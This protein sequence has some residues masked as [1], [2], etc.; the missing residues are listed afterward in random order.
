MQL[1]FEFQDRGAPATEPGPD[2]LECWRPIDGWP[3]Y[4]VSDWGRVHTYWRPGG[5]KG[6][7]GRHSIGLTPKIMIGGV[8]AKGH[9]RVRLLKDA[10][11]EQRMVY[12]HTLV[13]EAFVGPRPPSMEA[14]HNDGNPANN[15][16]SNLRWD[17]SSNNARDRLKHGVWPASS[18]TESMIPSIWRRLV[19]GESVSS[20]A[21]ELEVKPHVISLIKN[22]Q[23][24]N[25]ITRYLPG[26]SSRPSALLTDFSPIH[27]PDELAYTKEELWRTMLDWPG[28]QFSNRGR[29]KT[30][31]RRTSRKGIPCDD[32]GMIFV[33]HINRNG[34]Y[35]LGLIDAHGRLRTLQIH[36]LLLSAFAGPKP[37]RLLH[38]CH[39]DGN[40][41]NNWAYNLRWDTP[42][43]NAADR[44][45]HRTI[46]TKA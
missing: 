46:V 31:K 39:S 19:L 36:S 9:R 22:G 10:S 40:K 23:T 42:K 17:T 26:W 14:C 18:L 8:N 11:R 20:I 1:A 12:I 29:V 37:H 4:E 21:R 6:I 44:K 41:L 27:V 28:Y 34:Y 24:W 16:L 2:D 13:L 5:G 30:N 25:H 3:G 45:L 43:G 38:A 35:C 15:H 7:G 32:G 33:P